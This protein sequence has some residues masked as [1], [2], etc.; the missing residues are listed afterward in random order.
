MDKNVT[1]VKEHRIRKTIE[2]LEKN[3]MQGFYVEKKEDVPAKV[4]EL[5]EQ[6]C[7]VSSGGSQTLAECGVIDMLLTSGQYDFHYRDKKGNTPA[8]RERIQRETFSMDVFLS[9]T[10][11]ITEKGELYNV[12]GN[13]NRVAAI[14]WGPK[15][16]IIV[17]GY[18]KLVKDLPEAVRRVKAEAAPA[19]TTRLFCETYC[20]EKGEC[21]SFQKDAD[22]ITAGCGSEGRICCQ[23]LMTGKQR[24]KNRIK[25]ILVGEALGY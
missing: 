6:G 9:G 2:N 20:M 13:G 5:L 11:A 24:L 7:T 15:S 12:D 3:C 4:A 21:V 19:N 10:N 25:V 1:A 22:D 17:A 16:V 14:A 18:N 23:Y 8:D